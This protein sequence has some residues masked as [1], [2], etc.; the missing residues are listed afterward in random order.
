MLLL[1]YGCA[2]LLKRYTQLPSGLLGTPE[3]APREA[4]TIYLL[5]R[6]RITA[7]TQLQLIEVNQV[8]MLVAIHDQGVNLLKEFPPEGESLSHDPIPESPPSPTA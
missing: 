3:K 4:D 7:H 8:K 2:Y 6:Q 1:I 5:H